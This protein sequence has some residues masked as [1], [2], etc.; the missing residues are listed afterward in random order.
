MES[1]TFL[2]SDVTHPNKLDTHCLTP[3]ENCAYGMK[4][5][6]TENGNSTLSRWKHFH[7]LRIIYSKLHDVALLINTTYGIILLNATFWVFIGIISGANYVIKLKPIANHLYVIAAVLW[8]SF[9]V[10]L[11]IMLAVSCSMAVNEC[12]RTPIIVQK[13]M[14]HDD[15]DREAVRELKNMFSQF[16]AMKIEFSAFGMYKIDMTF[17]CGIFGATLSYF[18][19]FL[20]M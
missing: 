9:C 18:I 7:N 1:S 3:I 14:L 13:I 11:M 12:N 5:I 8:T 17:L 20:Q 10:A 6:C 19:I 15:N 16:K 2:T 4:Y